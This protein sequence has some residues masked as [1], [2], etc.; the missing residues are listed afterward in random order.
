MNDDLG[1]IFSLIF[2]IEQREREQREKIKMY[3]VKLGISGMLL[4]FDMA[5]K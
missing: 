4:Y 1:H 2:P 3:A 5:S